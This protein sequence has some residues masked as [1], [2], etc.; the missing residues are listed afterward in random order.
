MEV[1][2]GA[3]CPP[4]GRTFQTDGTAHGRTGVWA[5]LAWPRYSRQT[6]R[7]DQSEGREMRPLSLPIALGKAGVAPSWSWLNSCHGLSM[8]FSVEGDNNRKLRSHSDMSL[9]TWLR[10]LLS[11][12]PLYTTRTHLSKCCTPLPM[13]TGRRNSVYFLPVH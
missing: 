1:R 7:L 3:V 9:P 13:E 12:E 2:E 5:G 10:G 6:R 8:T 4:G 11:W